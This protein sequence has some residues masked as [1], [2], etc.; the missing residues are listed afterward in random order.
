MMASVIRS[1]EY[2]NCKLCILLETLMKGIAFGYFDKIET[3]L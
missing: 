3:R 2:S 1:L